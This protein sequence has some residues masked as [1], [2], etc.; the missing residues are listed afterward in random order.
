MPEPVGT[1]KTSRMRKCECACG[2]VVRISRRWIAV[3][4]PTC[5]CG[6]RLIPEDADDAALV[7]SPAELEDH[8]AILDYSQA[9]ESA[10]HG[11][12]GP[13]RAL[14]NLGKSY[15]PDATAMERVQRERRT[16]AIKNR[17][18]ALRRGMVDPWKDESDD[19]PF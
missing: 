11:Q 15:S 16:R 8:P 12:A 1:V 13:A 7:L 14:R 5:P 18:G 2:Y 4:L 3:G 19:I 6:G 9:V 10:A 17:L